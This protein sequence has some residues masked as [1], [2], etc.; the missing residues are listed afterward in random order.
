MYFKPLFPAFIETQLPS[1][2]YGIKKYFNV[3]LRLDRN[4]FLN[5]GTLFEK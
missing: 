5:S 2:V 1:N 3:I 4:S